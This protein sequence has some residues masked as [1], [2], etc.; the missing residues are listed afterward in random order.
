MPD[1]IILDLNM[2]NLDGITLCNQIKSNLTTAHI[3]I[4][5]ITA[6]VLPSD[7][8]RCWEAG[9]ADFI[10]KPIVASTLLHRVK[11]I[12]QSK[13]RFELLTEQTFKDQLTGV[14]NRHYL[15]SEVPT[16]LKVSSREK[17]FFGVVMIDIDFFKGFNDTY[18]HVEG[19]K[20][21]KMVAKTIQNVLKRPQDIVVRYGGEEFVV[22]LPN[23]PPSG[24]KHLA[25]KIKD[26]V[27][28][29]N[30]KNSTSGHQVVTISGG[31]IVTSPT[32][33]THTEE[34]INQ[35]DEFLFKSKTN[36]RNQIQG[37][38]I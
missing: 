28:D 11:N 32:A 24:C 19:D 17:Q 12:L 26:A 16:L 3:P 36:G 21:L 31:Y 4:I 20:C 35:A 37:V 29:L 27:F 34:L 8:D 7:Q 2:P 30:I 9:A 38:V 5:F 15:M 25:N 6:S 18:G 22:F 1:L 13:L 10:A 14:F 33:D 23:T